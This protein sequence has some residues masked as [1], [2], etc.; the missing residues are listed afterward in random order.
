MERSARDKATAS[1]N[2]THI[3]GELGMKE[4]Y[5]VC[6]GDHSVQLVKVN[7]SAWFMSSVDCI[8]SSFDK[9]TELHEKDVDN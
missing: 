8:S 4:K 1:S 5:Q 2:E 7:V 3:S 6:L 9:V